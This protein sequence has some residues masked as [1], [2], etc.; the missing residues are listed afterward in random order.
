M[1]NIQQLINAVQYKAGVRTFSARFAGSQKS[2]T[3]KADFKINEGDYVVVYSPSSGYTIVEVLSVDEGCGIDPHTDIS[4]KWAVC[5]VDE[6][7]YMELSQADAELRQK[8]SRNVRD[9]QVDAVLASLSEDTRNAYIQAIQDV[10]A[11]RGE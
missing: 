3:Y 5:K 8:I 1:N 2:Y 11:T 4:Y 6:D 7:R 10:V 9:T